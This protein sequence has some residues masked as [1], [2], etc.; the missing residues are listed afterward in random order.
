MEFNRI[1]TR[2]KRRLSGFTLPEVLVASGLSGIVLM[3]LAAASMFTARSF[4]SI[5]NHH[6]LDQKSRVALDRMTKLIRQSDSLTAYEPTSMT[7]NHGTN[8]VLQ[9]TYLPVRRELVET[10]GN[11]IRVVL[12]E[13][14]HVNFRVFQRNTASNTFNQ[15]P[16]VV[17]LSDAKLVQMKWTCSRKI[18]GTKFNVE[19]AQSAKIVLRN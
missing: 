17:G 10:I 11:S 19:H 9:Y 18:L 8:G 3:A 12:T 13:C 2:P 6:E 4:S 1:S 5:S 14:D 15:F 7:F 16:A